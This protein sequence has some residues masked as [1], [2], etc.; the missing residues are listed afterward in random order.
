M[1]VV[2]ESADWIASDLAGTFADESDDPGSDTHAISA[3]LM[4][5]AAS[6]KIR[7]NDIW[8]E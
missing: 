4:H 5:S 6:V 1:G 7:R 2:A 8:K 3:A